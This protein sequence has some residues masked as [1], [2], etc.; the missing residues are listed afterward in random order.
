MLS[1]FAQGALNFPPAAAA[2]Q[3]QANC[4]RPAGDIQK[5]LQLQVAVCQETSGLGVEKI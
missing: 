5:G 2:A 1:N 3:A 4:V